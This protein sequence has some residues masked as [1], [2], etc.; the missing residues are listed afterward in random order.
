MIRTIDFELVGP[1]SRRSLCGTHLVRS[2][3]CV[4]QP[5]SEGDMINRIDWFVP[6][7]STAAAVFVTAMM[8]SSNAAAQATSF[9]DDVQPIM[10]IRCVECHQP[11]GAGHDASGL[12]LTT[13]ADVM[14]GTT[15]GPV[16]VPYSPLTSNL[17]AVIERRTDPAI[18]MPHQGKKLSPCERRALRTWISQGAKNN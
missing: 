10:Q 3:G 17:I 1:A 15:F 16:V 2:S 8:L 5:A 11:G 4:P 18:W 7:L 9:K 13:F 14:K 12:D 6:I